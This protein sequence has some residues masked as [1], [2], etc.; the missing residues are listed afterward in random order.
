M[1]A[2]G[3]NLKAVVT[4]RG[5]LLE[6]GDAMYDNS[7]DYYWYRIDGSGMNIENIYEDHGV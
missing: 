6:D 5:T 3:T 1:E 4:Y 2:P 7:F